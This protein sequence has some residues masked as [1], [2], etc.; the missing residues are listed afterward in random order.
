MSQEPQDNLNKHLNQLEQELSKVASAESLFESQA[1]Q[2]I[3]ELLSTKI[4][5]LT[6]DVTSSKYEKDHSGYVKALADLHAHRNLLRRLQGLATPAYRARLEE[7]LAE[8]DDG[9]R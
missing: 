2:L 1:G 6:R 9:K 5:I 7:G 4:T 3:V 8:L